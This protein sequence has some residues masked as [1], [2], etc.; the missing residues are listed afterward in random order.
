MKYDILRILG[1]VLLVVGGQ[2]AVRIL[3]D[4]DNAG[5]LGWLNGGFATNLAIYVV[6]VVAGVLLAGWADGKARALGR[7]T[8]RR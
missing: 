4:H 2:G 7:G 1:A 6:T 8:D 5:L 3:I